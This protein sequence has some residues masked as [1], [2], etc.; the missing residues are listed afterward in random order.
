MKP[1]T[2][3]E[4]P[5]QAS[6]KHLRPMLRKA[7]LAHKNARRLAVG[8]QMML[9]FE[10]RETVRW[11]VLE[12]CRVEG[13][14]DPEAIQHELDTYNKLI[15]AEGEL[16]ATLFIEITEPAEIRLGLDQLLGIDE[17]LALRIG[18]D[19]LPARFDE[20]QTNQDHI[21]AVHY[22]RVTVPPEASAALARPDIPAAVEIDHRSYRARTE[23]GSEIRDQMVLDLSGGRTELVP[24]QT[25]LA[26]VGDH[27]RA[28]TGDR[29]EILETHGAVRVVRP[30]RPCAPT[31]LIVEPVLPGPRFPDAPTDLLAAL[32]SLAQQVARQI[33]AE[34][35]ACRIAIDTNAPFRLDLYAPK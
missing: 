25:K 15:P 8:N 19:V 26:P 4:L 1:L 22:V 13:L 10:D 21:S 24:G 33:E 5:S 9:L 17:C 20:K 18:Q 7:I 23:L 32:F 27:T 3:A 28:D 14:R 35:G 29:D 6:F 2:L 11:Q 30:A 31:H 34:H 16:S 12:M